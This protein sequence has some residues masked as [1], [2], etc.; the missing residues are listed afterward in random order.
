MSRIYLWAWTQHLFFSVVVNIW[1]P[2]SH[3]VLL[4]PRMSSVSPLP[5]LEEL[6]LHRYYC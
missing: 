4:V 1:T 5:T 3:S 2:L 6:T